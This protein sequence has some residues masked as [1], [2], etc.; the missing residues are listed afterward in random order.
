MMITENFTRHFLH[1]FSKITNTNIDF[2]KLLRGEI[3]Q[4]KILIVSILLFIFAACF[5]TVFATGNMANFA[6]EATEN[7]VGGVE[8]ALDTTG[9]AIENTWDA[10][11]NTAQS[12]GNVVE[13]VTET[14]VN[15]VRNTLDTTNSAISDTTANAEGYTFLGMSL[16]VWMWIILIAIVVIAVVLICKYMKEHNDD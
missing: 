1:I 14:T 10:T 16:D 5:S 8:N 7:V 15:G 6:R 12:V 9:N 11:K 2:T 13:N 4:K 3:M